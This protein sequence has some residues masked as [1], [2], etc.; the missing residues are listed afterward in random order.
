MIKRLIII[1]INIASLQYAIASQCSYNDIEIKIK[2]RNIEKWKNENGKIESVIKDIYQ[3]L[4]V[5]PRLNA[6]RRRLEGVKLRSDEYQAI[7]EE[8]TTNAEDD[9]ALTYEF[10]RTFEDLL[11]INS[12]QQLTHKVTSGL[13]IAALAGMVRVLNHFSYH[14]KTVR[15]FRNWRDQFLKQELTDEEKE[16]EKKEDRKDHKKTISRVGMSAGFAALAITIKAVITE[17]QLNEVE[18]NLIEGI[19]ETMILLNGLQP[20]EDPSLESLY[21]SVR[22]MEEYADII[23]ENT[24]DDLIYSLNAIVSLERI[25][26]EKE[27]K[28]YKLERQ[29]EYCY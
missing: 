5:K 22:D 9:L 2:K 20:D 29:I 8:V 25:L 4:K 18:T 3:T 26:G 23:S 10:Q 28:I 1:F 15:A 11:E 12:D 7:L 27:N 6:L 21:N 24:E 17:Y 19:K 14:N 13:S 16:S